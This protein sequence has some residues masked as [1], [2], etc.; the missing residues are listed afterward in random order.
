MSISKNEFDILE[1][2]IATHEPKP[3]ASFIF[4][5]A[6]MTVGDVE[7]GKELY[8]KIKTKIEPFYEIIR[9]TEL[10]FSGYTSF[11]LYKA[12]NRKIYLLSVNF[13]ELETCI[14]IDDEK[15]FEFK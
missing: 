15:W 13:Q 8:K 1:E 14:Q 7:R 5:Y 3:N 6:R 12:V 11:A 4:K 9:N 2:F 10:S